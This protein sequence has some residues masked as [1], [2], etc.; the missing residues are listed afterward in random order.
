MKKI[1]IIALLVALVIQLSQAQKKNATKEPQL[2]DRELFFDNPEISGGQLSPDGTMITFL[3]VHKGKLNIWVKKFDEPFESAKPI[4]ADTLRPIGGYFWT[5]DSKFVL[6]AQDKGGNEN[7]NV[8]AVDPKAPIESGSGAPPSRNLTPIE[9]VRTII[10]NVSRKNPD[11]LWVGLNNRDKAWHDLY[12]LEISTGKLT[13]LKENKDRLTGYFFDWDENLRLATRS[14]DDGSTEILAATESGFNKIFECTALESC[15]PSG[16]FDK[17]NK[18]FYL[19]SNKGDQEDLTKL[20]LM[21][22]SSK[23]IK[24]VEGDP[25]KKV[26]FGGV[27]VSAITREIQY[28]TY[29]DAKTR[30]YFKNK[31]AESH[32]KFLQ[33]KFPGKEIGFASFTKD[34]KK[35]LIVAYS[36]DDPGSVYF[37][38]KTSKKVIKQY[39]PRPKL[40]SLPLAKMEP[41]TYK[42]SDGLEIPGYLVLPLG[43]A[44]KNLPTIVVPHGGPWGRDTWGFNSFAQFFANRGYAVLLPNFRASTGFGKKFLNAGNKEWGQKMQDDITWGVKHLIAKGIADPKNV[45]IMGGSYGGYATLAGLAFTP[46]VY[47]AGVSVV[48]PSNLITLLGSIPPYWEAIRKTFYLRMGD[49]STPEGKALLEKQSPLFSASK[50]KAPLLVVQGANDPRVKKHESDQIVVALRDLGRDVEY[51]CAQDE[52]HGFRNADNTMAMLAYAEKF[53]AKH[54][55]GRYQESMKADV[56][57]KLEQMLVDVKTVKLADAGSAKVETPKF[58]SDLRAEKSN[59]VFT[60]SGGGQK[61]AMNMTRDVKLENGKWIVT[62]A[63]TS[64]QFSVSD[65]NVFEPKTLKATH[66][67]IKQGPINIEVDYTESGATGTTDMNGVKKNI[68][69]SFEKHVLSDGAGLDLLIARMPIKE[70][71][72]TVIEVYDGSKDKIKRLNVK[73]VAKESVTVPAGTFEAYK[74]EVAQVD[75]PEKFTSWMGTKDL[76]MIKSEGLVP[77][78]PN[79]SITVELK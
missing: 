62:D 5:D 71:F 39:T 28:T 79:A 13:L 34:E 66:R 16:F 23:A 70:N 27:S 64:P 38:D 78:M 22:P 2:I 30:W 77:E 72:A 33:S 65:Q 54:L 20:Y 56:S 9:G 11:L 36:D 50:I 60:F 59:Y 40:Q 61:M 53:F 37:Y 42:S 7:F 14:A 58:T 63:V 8:Y 26:D 24:L 19:Q 48:G 21:D 25:L 52:G 49:P 44:P 68:N 18:S 51:L 10:Y 57:K 74:I 43:K 32:Y 1:L 3:K 4:T 12:K 55:G 41:I 45:G 69:A 31:D 17:E 46:D 73:V 15:F 29:T 76:N 6:Y 67:S 75:G 47:A 35:A